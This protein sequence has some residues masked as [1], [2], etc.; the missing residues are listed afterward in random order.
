MQRVGLG[1]AGLVHLGDDGWRGLDAPAYGLEDLLQVSGGEL[2]AG[3]LERG[4]HAVAEAVVILEQR[5]AERRAQLR[6]DLDKAAVALPGLGVEQL[7]ALLFGQALHG[8]AAVFIVALVFVV[9]P[10][11]QALFQR[12]RVAASDDALRQCAA[13]PLGQ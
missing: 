7:L 2:A 11:G 3:L 8:A 5:V 1:L 6:G 10:V 4:V 12:G 9:A 13:Q